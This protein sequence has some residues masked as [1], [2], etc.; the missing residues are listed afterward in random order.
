MWKCSKTQ[1][2]FETKIQIEQAVEICL[3]HSPLQTLMFRFM[4]VESTISLETTV[5][6]V[7]IWMAM[8]VVLL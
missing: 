7:I 1:S 3:F 2:D 8:A 5:A 4:L 6:Y